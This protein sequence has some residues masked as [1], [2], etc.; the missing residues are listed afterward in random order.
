MGLAVAQNLQNL[1][2]ATG[3]PGGVSTSSARVVET[4]SWLTSFGVNY[5]RRPLVS[6]EDNAEISEVFID[7]QFGL[8][9]GLTYGIYVGFELSIA[10]PVG[11]VSGPTLLDF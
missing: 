8:D 7:R 9:L 4:G 1:E 3:L 2:P 11:Y 10:M 6:R 5:A